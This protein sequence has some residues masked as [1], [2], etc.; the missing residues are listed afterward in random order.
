MIMRTQDQLS[1]DD[2][3]PDDGDQLIGKAHRLHDEPDIVE[4]REHRVAHRVNP[5]PIREEEEEEL[6]EADIMEELDDDDLKKMEGP[7]A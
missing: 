4:D 6:S 2:R 5:L 1:P 3:E 7:D